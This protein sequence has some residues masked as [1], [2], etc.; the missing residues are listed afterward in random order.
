[1]SEISDLI[2]TII[3]NDAGFEGPWDAFS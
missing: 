2:Q 3:M 1:M